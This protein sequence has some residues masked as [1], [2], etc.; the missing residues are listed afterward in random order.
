MD[1]DL[2]VSCEI[3]TFKAAP[4]DA[5]FELGLNKIKRYCDSILT[6]LEKL[7]HP[8]ALLSRHKTIGYPR[9][10]NSYKWTQ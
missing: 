9:V 10:W 3:L 4:L 8:R 1:M 2:L 7:R 5:T 6:S